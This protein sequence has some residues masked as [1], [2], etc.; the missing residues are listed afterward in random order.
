MRKVLM[1]S[2]PIL[3]LAFRPFFLIAGVFAALWLPLWLLVWR[4]IIPLPSSLGPIGWHRHEMLF[5]YTMAVVAG[6]LLTAVWNW[7]GRPPSRA[8]HGGGLLALVALWAVPRLGLP[9]SALAPRWA[10]WLLAL[11]DVAFPLVLAAT[12]LGA[13]WPLRAWRNLGFAPMMALLATANGVAHLDALGVLGGAGALATTFALDA[14]VLLMV[15]MGGRVIPF[16]TGNALPEAGVRR[17]PAADRAAIALVAATLAADLLPVAPEVPGVLA[18]LAAAANI[19]RMVS[20]SSLA[21]R[22]SPILWVLHLAYGWIAVGLA[23]KGL[24]VFVPAV[25]PVLA[26]HALTVGGIG[27]LT[28]GMMSRVSLGHSGRPILAAPPTVAAYALVNLAALVRVGMP[29]VAPGQYFA[30]LVTSGALW[31]AAFALFVWVY[32]PILTRPRAARRLG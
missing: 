26:T 31:S 2:S 10:E 20:W 13:L 23:L 19:W 32:W 1:L 25:L 24:A 27:G 7:T 21:T 15:V 18:L 3:S 12:L 6:F 4:G 22:I 9:I 5:G 29:L 17:V 28:L 14:I 8:A 30:S 16:F 11:L